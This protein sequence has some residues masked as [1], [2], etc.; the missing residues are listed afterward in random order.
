MRIAHII[1]TL[2]LFLPLA[3][4]VFAS[5]PS[6]D[7][8][9]WGL[10][11]SY[12]Q[13]VGDLEVA[14]NGDV[15]ICGEFGM[16]PLIHEGFVNAVDFDPGPGI[17]EIIPDGEKTNA[18]ITRFNS[19][20]EFLWVRSWDADE[21]S[22]IA[23]DNEGY[24]YVT[25]IY[26]GDVDLDPG[27]G[28]EY[29]VGGDTIPDIYLSK[30]SPDGN[31]LWAR[32]WG[33]DSYYEDI[34]GIIRSNRVAGVEIDSSG[35]VYVAG[36]FCGTAD[37]NPLAAHSTQT[38]I[39]HRDNF[40]LKCSP[41]GDFQWVRTW[42][43]DQNWSSTMDEMT[44]SSDD[45]IFI[46]GDFTGIVDFDPGPGTYIKDNPAVQGHYDEM[47]YVSKFNV[48]GE[49]IWARV[50]GPS[51]ILGSFGLA[52]DHSESVYI[53]GQL[54]GKCDFD[55]GPG[56]EILES[57]I[58]YVPS[59]PNLSPTW[60]E[61][62]YILKLDGE[63]NFE[64]AITWGEDDGNRGDLVSSLAIG[65]QHALYGGGFF[66]LPDQFQNNVN[67]GWFC[68]AIGLDCDGNTHWVN[69]WETG[70]H[71]YG[72]VFTDNSGWVYVVGNSTMDKCPNFSQEDQTYITGNSSYPCS[73][74][75]LKLHPDGTFAGP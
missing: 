28:E 19:H 25:G 32:N 22:A 16:G 70:D 47:A 36:Q 55:P 52:T 30:F 10:F 17:T 43:G 72:E 56:T 39:S 45:N 1:S 41:D 4:N 3:T 40:L 67:A 7:E 63:G 68:M 75:L 35:N 13:E 33:G 8:P 51:E 2:A 71:N 59:D 37:F 5:I 15:I 73:S 62:P 27:P 61:D 11:F 21:A 38:A 66:T 26:R 24:I 65:N 54:N 53:S 60:S 74:Y 20:G 69:S 9:G 50:F 14:D 42:P 23:L 6:S 46:V 18:Y 31:L 64:W 57:E 49:F 12:S 34:W 44:I 58:L 29:R 48:D